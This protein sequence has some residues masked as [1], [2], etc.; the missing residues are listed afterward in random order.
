M[1]E[2]I[3]VIVISFNLFLIAASI[4]INLNKGWSIKNSNGSKFDIVI[5][6]FVFKINFVFCRAVR[7]KTRYRTQ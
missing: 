1:I 7:I 6:K 2:R 5:L 3:A 4:E